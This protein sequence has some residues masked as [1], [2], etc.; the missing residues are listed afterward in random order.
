MLEA[1]RRRARAYSLNYFIIHTGCCADEFLQAVGCR[2]DL[3]R[4]GCVEAPTPA[5]ADLLVIQGALT[6]RLVPEVK[7]IFEQMPSYRSVLAVGAC[8]CTGG[9]FSESPGIVPADR[10]VPVDVFVPGCPPRPEAIMHGIITLQDK[11]RGMHRATQKARNI[12]V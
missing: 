3:E 8:A 4:F 6:E 5:Q 9:L 1:I 11:I 10:V 12:P 2:Y 7:K